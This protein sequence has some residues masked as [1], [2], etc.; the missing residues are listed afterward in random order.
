MFRLL[1]LGAALV[2]AM[3]L[4]ACGGS[5]PKLIPQDRADRLSSLADQIAQRTED[6]KC[7][8]AQS[9]LRRAR[10]EA[11][12]LPRRVDR[13]LKRN[14]DAWLDQIGSRIPEDC[15]PKA[16]ATPTETAT[17]TPT[18][19][20]TESPTPTPTPTASPTPT[21]SPTP[22]GGDEQNSPPDD[23]GGVQ[24]PNTGGVDPG[25]GDG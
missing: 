25:N 21:S 6:H 15:K 18:P 23:D 17:E 19:T 14:L 1:P 13:R 10:S 8:S 22:E 3:L 7:A 2:A 24:L 16:S 20:A 5:N 9:A 11:A 4:S 12:E